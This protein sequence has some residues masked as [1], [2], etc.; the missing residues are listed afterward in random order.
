MKR[1]SIL[2]SLVAVVLVVFAFSM[3]TRCGKSEKEMIMPF[4][5]KEDVDF[6]GKMWTAIKD[7]QK[8]LVQSDIIPSQPPHGAFVRVY[9][10]MVT[11]DGKPYHVIVKDNFTPDKELAAV[12]VIVQRE[13]GYDSD[14]NNW[15]WVKYGPDGSIGKNDKDMALAGRVAKGM[16]MGC[17]ACH[18]A[19]SDKD[20]V[21]INDAETY[22]R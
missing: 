9:Y 22:G 3:I 10:N 18:K 19:A 15:F 20:Y 14:N 16:D 1:I 5:G 7:Y 11:V 4:G 2:G 8:W 13:A 12:T 17:I 21:F 6:A